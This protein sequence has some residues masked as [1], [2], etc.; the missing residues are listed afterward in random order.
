[1]A[2]REIR[3]IWHKWEEEAI[4]LFVDFVPG[5]CLL[6][7]GWKCFKFYGKTFMKRVVFYRLFLP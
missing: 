5:I 6:E 4:L 2:T 3:R 1:M 7:N